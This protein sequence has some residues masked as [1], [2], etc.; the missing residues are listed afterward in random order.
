MSYIWLIFRGFLIAQFV[1]LFLCAADVRSV[2]RWRKNCSNSPK[3]RK[4]CRTHELNEHANQQLE[5]EMKREST[6]GIRHRTVV[7]LSI[8]PYFC[9]VYFMYINSVYPVFLSG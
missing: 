9:W 2:M 5:T 6:L 8:L 3:K 7:M 4:L 1:T